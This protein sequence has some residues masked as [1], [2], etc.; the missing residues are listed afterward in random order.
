MLRRRI[1]RGTEVQ[2]TADVQTAPYAWLLVINNMVCFICLARST[3]TQGVRICGCGNDG[4]A[5]VLARTG[6]RAGSRSME[7]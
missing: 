6:A 5:E 1:V 7:L 4:V 2:R 3:I